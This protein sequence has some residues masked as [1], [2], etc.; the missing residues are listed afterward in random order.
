MVLQHVRAVL[1]GIQH[2][3]EQADPL[4]LAAAVD[5]HRRLARGQLHAGGEPPAIAGV[6]AHALGAD[7]DQQHVGAGGVGEGDL[8]PVLLDV[9]QRWVG[10]QC[11]E[12]TGHPRQ[13]PGHRRR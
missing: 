8:E 5:G 6:A 12:V 9:G 3:V 4:V 7:R 13:P 11:L 1:R 2:R 10:Q